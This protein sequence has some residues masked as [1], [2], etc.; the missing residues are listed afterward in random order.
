MARRAAQAVA[1]NLTHITI[2]IAHQTGTTAR[3]TIALQAGARARQR[4]GRAAGERGTR[5][6]VRR[7]VHD[8]VPEAEEV[9]AGERLGKE[10]GQ[11]VVIGLAGLDG[12][13]IAS[14]LGGSL[15]DA[16]S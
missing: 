4:A 3:R 6:V 7:D 1:R 11:L 16:S 8:D 12:A 5:A 15:A 9:L 2:L 13:A 14:Q 10:V